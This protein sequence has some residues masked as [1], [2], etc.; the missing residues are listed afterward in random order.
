VATE[1]VGRVRTCRRGPARL[2]AARAWIEDYRREMEA[3]FDRLEVF[4][5]RT[6]EEEA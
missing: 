6:A 3:R 4:L 5:E 2:D 1:K